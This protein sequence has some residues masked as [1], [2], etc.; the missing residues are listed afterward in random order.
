MEERLL[1]P[2]DIPLIIT[3]TSSSPDT[4]RKFEDTEPLRKLSD[5]PSRKR[6]LDGKSRNP[7][8][9]LKYEIGRNNSATNLVAS[10]AAKWSSVRIKGTGYHDSRKSVVKIEPCNG[11]PNNGLKDF[12]NLTSPSLPNSHVKNNFGNVSN[13]RGVGCFCNSVVQISFC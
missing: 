1:K 6:S 8:G 4:S 13:V 10:T 3:S 5:A 12:Q 7:G 2:V 11:A 9:S